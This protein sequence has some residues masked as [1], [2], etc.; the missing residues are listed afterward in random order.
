M[1]DLDVYSYFEFK[2]KKDQKKT[3]QNFNVNIYCL[4]LL[5]HAT[6]AFLSASPFTQKSGGIHFIFDSYMSRTFSL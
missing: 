2:K 6:Y 4:L 1:Y 5:K 3:F